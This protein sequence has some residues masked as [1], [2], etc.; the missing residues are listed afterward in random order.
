METVGISVGVAVAIVLVW[1]ASI[2]NKINARGGCPEC[3]TPLPGF[4]RPTSLKQA[5]WGG[6]TCSD[7]GTEMDRNGNEIERVMAKG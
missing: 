4:R 2:R 6:W 1:A 7:C 5:I 3:G